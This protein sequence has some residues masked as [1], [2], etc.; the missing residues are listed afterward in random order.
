[1]PT[2][3]FDGLSGPFQAREVIASRRFPSDP[4][5]WPSLLSPALAPE[6]K[7]LLKPEA[8]GSRVAVQGPPREAILLAGWS[9]SEHPHRLNSWQPEPI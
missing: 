4:D 7:A 3:K 2:T 9:G 1:M 8:L 6:S 5:S